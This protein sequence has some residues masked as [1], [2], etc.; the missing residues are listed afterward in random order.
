MKKVK[1]MAYHMIRTKE[2]IEAGKG[3][4]CWEI[5]GLDRM[6]R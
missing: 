6:I 3:D 1:C 2:K 4:R 5:T